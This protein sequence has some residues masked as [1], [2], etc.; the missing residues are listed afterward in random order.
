MAWKFFYYFAKIHALA[1]FS[2]DKHR[3][4][5]YYSNKSVLYGCTWVAG[6]SIELILLVNSIRFTA[7]RFTGSEVLHFVNIT[8]LNTILLKALF[9]YII[10]IVQAKD[11]VVLINEAI[12]INQVIN[13][14]YRPQANLYGQRFYKLCNTKK[15]CLFMQF[16]LLFTSFYIYVLLK[17]PELSEIIFGFL[18]VYAHFSTVLV[19]G[20][21]FYGSL[22]YGYDF[23]YFL[24]RKLK[25]ILKKVQFKAKNKARIKSF[26]EA[27][28]ELDKLSFL[29]TRVNLYIAKINRILVIQTTGELL[30]AFTMITSAVSNWTQN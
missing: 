5:V 13:D 20:V 26:Y 10:Q 12:S 18:L 2:Y 27:C 1:Y 30:G 19:S 16:V 25:F 6:Y 9:V 3:K 15:W 29:H 7:S 11:V 23:Y 21:S 24:N 14:E 4:K 8:E 22:L 28:D 17:E